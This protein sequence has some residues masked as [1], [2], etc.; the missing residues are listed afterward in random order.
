MPEWLVR[1]EGSPEAVSVP[2][3]VEVATGL[4]DGNWLP[5]DEV[6][7]PNDAEWQSIENHPTFAEIA[8]EIEPL[9]G[10]G[11]DETTLDM[12]PLIDV[13]LVLLI[14]FILTITYATLE[15]TIEIPQDNP[16]EKGP[17]KVELKDIRDKVFVLTA[18]MDGERPV[19][20]I[21]KKEVA[22]D[23]IAGEMKQIIDSTG[24][25]QMVIDI[26]KDVP[27]GVETLILDA[28][29]GNGVHEIINNRRR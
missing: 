21:E 6:K 5:S 10:E 24:R 17:A 16:D 26:D 7:G 22:I 25:N 12:N 2:S 14:F 28:A 9:K 4:R 23:Q 3:A 1:K 11:P 20:R 29:K 13:C 18:R 19:V 8:E 15:R 27:W